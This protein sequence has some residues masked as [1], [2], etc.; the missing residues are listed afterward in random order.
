METLE[1]RITRKTELH[2]RYVEALPRLG[3]FPVGVTEVWNHWLSVARLP[4]VLPPH[5]VCRH[6]AAAGIEARPFWKPMHRQP[7]FAQAE[8]WITGR[9]DAWYAS[10][11]CLP[12]GY[13]LT[14]EAQTLVVDALASILDH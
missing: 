13:S 8:A 1:D 11:I 6:L 9:S 5:L 4:Q 7:V 10:G 12:S 3:W 2:D 14:D